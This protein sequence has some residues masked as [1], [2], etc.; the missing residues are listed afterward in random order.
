MTGL[1]AAFTRISNLKW[2]AVVCSLGI[3]AL[4]WQG[5]LPLDLPFPEVAAVITGAWSVWLLSQN[6]PSGW[7]VGL[8]SVLLFGIVF[9]EVRLYAEV[10]IQ[11]FYFVTSL[12]AIW[13]WIRGGTNR[14]Q[15]PVAHVP[16]HLMLWTVPAFVVAWVALRWLLIEVGGAAPIWDSLTTVMSLTAHVYLMFRYVESWY[17][18]I[19]VDVIYVPLYLSRDLRL[20]SL[21]YVG[22]LVMSIRGLRNFR[23][24]VGET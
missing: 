3:A 15:R 2:M 4:S 22:F 23:T 6:R 11:V 24:L 8:V 18:W 7:W 9:F 10:G 17:L 19:A 14:S 5:A 1:D 12:Q 20:T 13:I 21:L 16:K